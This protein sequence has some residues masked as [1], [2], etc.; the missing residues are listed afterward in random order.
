[1]QITNLE[2]LAAVLAKAIENDE[3]LILTTTEK[4]CEVAKTGTLKKF[5]FALAMFNNEL[6]I[7][8]AF[9]EGDSEPEWMEDI[10]AQYF[11]ETY[12]AQ[13]LESEF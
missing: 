9:F 8:F 11:T 10:G 12:L 7:G 6:K 4:Y 5:K 1:M 13:Q 2:D 3:T